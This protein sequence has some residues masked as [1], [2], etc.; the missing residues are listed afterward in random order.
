MQEEISK[1]NRPSRRTVVRGVAWTAPVI[2][3]GIAAPAFAASPGCQPVVTFSPDSCKCPGQSVG[4]EEFVY[5]LKFCVTDAAGCPTTTGT[6]IINSV[7]KSNG[8]QLD[9]TPNTC[10]P[11]TLPSPATPVG[12]CTTQV[13]RFTGVNSGNFLTVNFTVTVGNN[14]TSYSTKVPSP[15]K[16]ADINQSQRCEPCV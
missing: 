12:T 1:P 15:P 2:A 16:C 6:F 4:T 5:Y 14:T 8:T 11:A 10:F 3:V 13:Y 7:E 9:L